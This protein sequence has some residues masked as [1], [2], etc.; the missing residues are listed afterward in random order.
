MEGLGQMDVTYHDGRY[1]RQIILDNIGKE[2][3]RKLNH[4]KVLVVGAGGLGSPLLQYIV[5]AGVGTIGIIDDDTVAVHNLQ[6]QVLYNDAQIGKSKA[7]C[8]KEF[9]V[10]L[11]PHCHVTAYDTRLT[12]DNAS[13]ITERYDLIAD[14]TD[15]LDTRYLIDR[16][17]KASGK[18]FVHA[19]L[20]EYDGR[21]A[22]FNYCGSSSYSDIFPYAPDKVAS[23]AQSNGIIGAFAGVVGS[24]QALEVIKT[25]IGN[26]SLVDKML[27]INGLSMETKSIRLR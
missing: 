12:Y 10:R 3:Q 18:P 13:E 14:C 25:I 8:A 5:A 20:C 6:R 27:L 16:I 15:N 24:I 4:A 26:P 7:E 23:F 21:V 17:S 11:N 19:S 1:N 2:G 22:L 9:V